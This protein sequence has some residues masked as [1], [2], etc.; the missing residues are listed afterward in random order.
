MRPGSAP[1][2]CVLAIS[3]AAAPANARDP[4]D[5]V[6]HSLDFPKDSQQYVRVISEFPVDGDTATLY[7]PAWNPGSYLIREYASG[8]DR[9]EARGEDGRYLALE[10]TGKSAWRVVLEGNGRISVE[11]EVHAGELSVNT[12]WTGPEFTLLNP[13]AVMLYT[14]STRDMTQTVHVSPPAGTG[15]VRTSLAGDGPDGPWRAAGFDELV[16]SPLVISGAEPLDFEQDGHGY[17]FLN[18]GDSR[19]WDNRQAADDVR[20]I[21]A[22]A[23]AL[24]DEVPLQRD[25]WFFNFLAERGGGLEHDHC[26]VMMASRWQMRDRDDYTRWLGLVS[27]EYFH[28]WNVRHMRPAAIAEYDY[29]DEQYSS[30]L[31]LAEGLTSYYDNLLLSRAK[32]VTPDEY[33]GRLADDI[34]RLEL[35][36]GR[37]QISLEQAS[38]DAWIRHYRQ[39][40]HSI[41]SEI[42]Y[43]TK[44][45]VLGF[46]LDARIREETRG[47]ASLDDVMREMWA[48]WSKRAY[49][50]GAFEDAV[51]AVAGPETRAW[52]EPLLSSPADPGLEEA[53]G[54]FGLELDRH[55]EKTAAEAAGLPLGAGLG[56]NW[57]PDTPWLVAEAVVAGRPGARAGVLPGDELLAIDGERVTPGNIE[58]RLKRLDPR[59]TVEL[60]TA[61]RGRVITIP[62]QLAEVRPAEYT[63]SIGAAPGRRQSLRLAD[64]LGQSPA[65][66]P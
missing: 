2:L 45:A 22:E 15:V 28:L 18:A 1:A 57:K 3:L 32:L 17:H 8:L 46:A 33:L 51:E 44:G 24:W 14:D 27:H 20:A 29:Q 56:I 41:N 36:P 13:A 40:P 58:D 42:S 48:R 23:N 54:Y 25:Y 53:L 34:H 47:R 37:Q 7:M 12:A 60:L 39:D 4:D 52:L 11:Y 5:A 16:D 49:P 50:D 26:T 19:L 66:E 21:V 9:I 43:Y 30:A 38:R 35:T 63:L 6:V 65:A 55:P 64:W 61:R 31:W 59:A 10:K 62:L